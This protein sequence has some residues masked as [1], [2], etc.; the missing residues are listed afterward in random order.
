VWGVR[1]DSAVQSMLELEGSRIAFPAP[2]AFAATLL[3]QIYLNQAGIHYT[4]SYVSSHDSVY[5]AVS[6]GLFVAGGG[7]K[8]TLN[9]TNEAVRSQLRILWESKKYTPHAIASH[10]RHSDQLV[11]QIKKA[12]VSLSSTPEGKQ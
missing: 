9:N 10:P 4:P 6:K 7:V 5:L 11:G 1:K 8:R 3:P 12:L 2:A